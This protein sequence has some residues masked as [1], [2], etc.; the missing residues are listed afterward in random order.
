MPNAECRMPNAECEARSAALHPPARHCEEAQP[1]RQSSAIL[2]LSSAALT[3]SK[4]KPLDCRAATLLAV[5]AALDYRV[6]LFLAVTV[7]VA[8]TGAAVTAGVAAAVTVVA[9]ALSGRAPGCL[10]RMRASASMALR[11]SLALRP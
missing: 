9:A 11:P 6:A 1:T 3:T 2:L 5:T 8:V 7:V 10:G 4:A